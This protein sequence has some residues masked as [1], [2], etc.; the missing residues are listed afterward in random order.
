[1]GAHRGRVCVCGRVPAQAFSV[2]QHGSSAPPPAAATDGMVFGVIA[3]AVI[4]GALKASTRGAGP[5]GKALVHT[6]QHGSRKAAREAAQQAGKGKPIHHSSGS[7]G[8]GHFHAVDKAGNK[9]TSGSQG[10]VHHNYGKK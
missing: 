1:M 9:I 4:K 10:G 8:G 3:R 5:S 6:V 7:G 2:Q